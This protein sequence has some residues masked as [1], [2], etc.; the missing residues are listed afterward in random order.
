MK[1]PNAWTCDPT[2]HQCFRN[3]ARVRQDACEVL[4]G[5]LDDDFLRD[6]E[7]RRNDSGTFWRIE[8]GGFSLL[9]GG[10]ALAQGGVGEGRQQVG[11]AG[12]RKGVE[13]GRRG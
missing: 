3:N 8:E 2:G 9:S 4:G 10:A 13:E 5:K 6:K 12:D 1:G 11:L 7:R